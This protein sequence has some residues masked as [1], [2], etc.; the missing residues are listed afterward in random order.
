MALPILNM[1]RK[2]FPESAPLFPSLETISIMIMFLMVIF[3]ALMGFQR[4][5]SRS[6]VMARF[7]MM[8][9]TV[10]LVFALITTILS[11]KW[12]LSARILLVGG[13]TP[14][15]CYYF[16]TKYLNG[17]EDV[18][19]V[20]LGFIFMVI[21]AG[22]YSFMNFINRIGQGQSLFSNE[23]YRWVY[24]EAPIVNFFV[25]PSAAVAAVIPAL[26][27]SLWYYNNGH[28]FRLPIMI[29]GVSSVLFIS[30][31]SFSRG[32]WLATA[33]TGICSLMILMHKSPIRTMILISVICVVVLFTGI[34]KFAEPILQS[35]E[36]S[37]MMTNEN[38][39]KGRAFHYQL[40]LRSSINH[41]LV[42]VGLGSYPLIF[43]E[44]PGERIPFIWF[45][46][47]LLL[48]LIPEIGF[49][50]AFAFAM[51]LALHILSAFKSGDSSP[52]ESM[53]RKA[54]S[55]GIMGFIIVASTSGC[56]LICYLNE[57]PEKTYFTAP[58]MIV[59]FTLLGVITYK[60]GSVSPS[61]NT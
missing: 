44:F 17:N 51:F 12:E 1:A 48:T 21:I 13:V 46:H 16:S 40:S 49:M 34:K 56:H 26:P 30:L 59:V 61:N 33:I 6:S 2:A 55:I 39:F 50:G 10:F 7:G 18:N 57:H 20:I 45:A 27:L 37:V 9:L 32:S 14:S 54:I 52:A 36:T 22:A 43:R 42:G 38:N 3:G 11:D 41:P 19:R 28:R 58:V 31:C 35:R 24:N 8:L 4:S 53:L 25:V 29:S 23:I 15:I 60:N 47:S 5:S